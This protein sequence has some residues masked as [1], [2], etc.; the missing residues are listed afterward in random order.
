M[1]SRI[2]VVSMMLTLLF[3]TVLTS[4]PAQAGSI[5]L[6]KRHRDI[7]NGYSIMPP[8]GATYVQKASKTL[9]ATWHVKDPKTEAILLSLTVQQVP[10]TKDKVDLHAHAAK[11]KNLQEKVIKSIVHSAK[12]TK[13]N[14]LDAVEI[15]VSIDKKKF[16][17]RQVWILAKPKVFLVFTVSGPNGNSRQLDADCTTILKTL[18]IIDPEKYLARNRANKVQGEKL[19]ASLSA[20]KIRNAI[21]RN[22][23]WYLMKYQGETIGWMKQV[24]SSMNLKGKDGFRITSWAM[25]QFP[26]A[27]VRLSKR[28][29]FATPDRKSE[30][31]CEVLRVESNDNVNTVEENGLREKEGLAVELIVDGES[32]SI[33]NKIP[34]EAESIY[35]PKV[36]DALMYRLI[37]RSQGGGYLFS[38]YN[39]AR[40]N[41][42]RF[43]SRTI[44]VA[45]TERIKTTSGSKVA[46]RLIDQKHYDTEENTVWVDSKG[47]VLRLESETKEFIIE[48]SSSRAVL[49][50]YPKANDN[51]KKLD[52]G[53]GSLGK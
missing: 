11:I 10:E 39:S 44:T 49:R 45:G 22:P 46:T 25:A 20:G 19:L 47:M 43:D 31:W 7:F 4:T 23:K 36:F 32:D 51:V 30:S 40:G 1:K 38:T 18:R 6:G 52:A 16:W 29:F 2:I 48:L 37:N 42:G 24:E 28:D 15:K 53:R 14:N 33:S 17:Q 27:G 21:E 41:R 12:V 3:V 13:I 8:S 35:T 5:K 34:P 9:L 50:K 26:K